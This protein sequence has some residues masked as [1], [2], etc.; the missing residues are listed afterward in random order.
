MENFIFCAVKYGIIMRTFNICLAKGIARNSDDEALYTFT[1]GNARV[2]WFEFFLLLISK[3]KFL[4]TQL[5]IFAKLLAI[6]ILLMYCSHKNNS[7]LAD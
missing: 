6:L 2:H 5:T 1:F 3:A 7:M 4:N